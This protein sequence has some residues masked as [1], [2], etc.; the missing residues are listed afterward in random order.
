MPI[1]PV[2]DL[3]DLQR[4]LGLINPVMPVFSLQQRQ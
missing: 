3:A 2:K 4:H 1:G